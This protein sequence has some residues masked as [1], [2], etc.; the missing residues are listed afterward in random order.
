M[1]LNSQALAEKE[2]EA[3]L[4]YKSS[5]SED[6]TLQSTFSTCKNKNC[7]TINE[8]M[9]SMDLQDICIQ[10]AQ[11]NETNNQDSHNEKEIIQQDKQVSSLTENSSNQDGESESEKYKRGFQKTNVVKKLFDTNSQNEVDGV[12]D[13]NYTQQET[14]DIFLD[15]E[16]C[17]NNEKESSMIE[18]HILQISKVQ[19]DSEMNESNGNESKLQ[20]NLLTEKYKKFDS[21]IL[22]LPLPNF[23]DES[24]TDRNKLPPKLTSNSK[25]TLKGSPGM[26][27]DLTDNAKSSEKDVNTLL[28]R[29]FCKHVNTKKQANNKS[30]V[31]VI[32]VQDTQN[33]PIPIKET[34]PYKLPINTDNSELNKPGAKLLR[35][36]ENLKLQMTLKRNEEWKQKEIELQTQEK[37][38]NREEESDCDLDGQERIDNLEL[39]DSGE[40]EP[41]ENDVCIKDKKRRKCLFADD[42]AEVTDDESSDISTEQIYNESDIDEVEHS[43]KRLINFK[44][45]NKSKKEDVD[46]NA[47]EIEIDQEEDEDLDADVETGSETNFKD[48]V[49]EVDNIY[50][51]IRNEKDRKTKQLIQ[52]FQDDSYIINSKDLENKNNQSKNIV[53]DV[54]K[55]PREDNNWINEDEND[56]SAFQQHTE[57]TTKSQMC[58][59]PLKAKTSMLDFVSPVTQ[60]SVL[61]ITLD[62]SNI[63]DVSENRE[64]LVD[65]QEFTSIGSTQNSL[66][67]KSPEHAYRNKTVSPK[68]LFD[69]IEE[70]VD[71]E[72][73]KQLCSGKFGSTQKTDFNLKDLSSQA[74][75][76]ESQLLKLCSGNFN[77]QSIDTKQLEEM[78]NEISQ[79][80]RLTLNED[81][82]DNSVNINQAKKISVST[83]SKKFIKIAFSGDESQSDEE[84]TFFRPKN[85]PVKR[86]NLSDSEEE[87]TESSDE[88][89]DDKEAEEYI[90]YDSEENEVVVAPKKDMKEIV[91][92]F[93]EEEAELSESDWDSADEDE[94][95]LDKLEFEEADNEHL[96]EDEVKNQLEKIHMRQIL[97]EDKREVRMLK[98]LLFEDGD[99]H[100]DGAGRERKFKWKNIGMKIILYGT[101]LFFYYT[102]EYYFLSLSLSL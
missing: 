86:L 50:K 26:I 68:K 39:S 71:D 47:S 40:S 51:D 63:K 66:L 14:A 28:D 19:R 53:A 73:L 34:L 8:K 35:L 46:D 87:N 99:L 17:V 18:N 98:E 44:H 10:D 70:T 83:D 88:E 67:N 1:I 38:L 11:K 43:S 89:N 4:F 25:V 78:E 65:E 7:S 91:A 15:K 55:T 56:T 100:M 69:D 94:K 77:M 52:E 76:S 32:H 3:E 5:D 49:N 75:I 37:E 36:K 57:V 22:G 93:L 95:G 6:D 13:I 41:E 20:D 42:E 21:H 48:A 30:E 29:F 12:S 96:D 82:S 102:E 59:T 74:N 90:D 81:L 101:L 72:Y 84:D 31:T 62:S 23:T 60:L 97:D 58:K 64:F 54:D 80:I 16:K 61:N 79:D 2:K 45:E 85:R 33:G 92:G 24:L 9:P 27:I